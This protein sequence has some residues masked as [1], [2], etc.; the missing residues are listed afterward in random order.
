MKVLVVID[1]AQSQIVV[2]RVI[3]FLKLLGLAD[4]IVAS[5][6]A[7]SWTRA[8]ALR[9]KSILAILE[10]QGE[11]ALIPVR[12]DLNAGG[13]PHDSRIH[14]TICSTSLPAVVIS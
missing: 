3:S 7:S 1:A 12:R 13:I 2:S 14:K 5:W 6:V 4:V 10:R 11:E 8:Y 9:R